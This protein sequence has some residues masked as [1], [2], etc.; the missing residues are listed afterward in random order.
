MQK[1]GVSAAV[2]DTEAIENSETG[3]EA[4]EVGDLSEGGITEPFDPTKIRVETKPMTVDLVIAR[5]KERALVLNPG[6]QRKAGIWKE[7]A[8]SRLIE[9]LLIRIP[10]P[11][12]YMDA[13][14]EDRWLV[15]DGLQRLT[16]LDNFIAKTTLSLTGLEFLTQYEGKR[17]QDLPRSLQ[18]RILETQV[19]VYLIE[20]GT[21]AEVKFNIFKRINTGGLPLSAQEIRHA[22]NQGRVTALLEKLSQCSEFKE[23]TDNG[24]RDD[25]MADRECVLRFLAFVL[26][27]YGQYRVKDF[28]SF[29]NNAMI[30]INQM[31]DEEVDDLGEQFRRAMVAAFALFGKRAFRKQHGADKWRYPINKALFEAWSADLNKLADGDIKRL[32]DRREAVTSAF[33]GL[34]GDPDFV[35]AISQGTGDTNKVRKRFGAIEELIQKELR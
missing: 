7:G 5:I 33:V 15:V 18:R 30:R 17:F 20:K 22:L 19:T 13:T 4:E 3:V 10:L 32:V 25:R 9:S 6:F 31:S 23:A 12:F 8:Q 16:S 2:E 27:P 34:M 14:D 21:P 29:L 35:Q 26:T 24:I 28:D 1:R 11:A